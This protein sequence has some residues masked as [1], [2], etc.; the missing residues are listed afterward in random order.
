MDLVVAN[1]RDTPVDIELV[2]L[3]AGADEEN[4]AVYQMRVTLPTMAGEEDMWRA[5]SFAPSREYAVQVSFIDADRAARY[6][7]EPTCSQGEVDEIGVRID[8]YDD[9]VRFHQSD[10]S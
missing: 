3:P 5:D 6:R 8:V 10:C 1:Y 7:Y 9:D 4:R 2:V